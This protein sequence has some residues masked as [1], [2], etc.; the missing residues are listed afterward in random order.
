MINR[1]IALE[2]GRVSFKAK[3]Y[4]NSSILPLSSLYDCYCESYS[5]VLNTSH[6]TLIQD[7]LNSP[8]N[9]FIPIWSLSFS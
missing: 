4:K 3:G 2:V 5:F 1:G 9:P 8:S 6:G 7:T